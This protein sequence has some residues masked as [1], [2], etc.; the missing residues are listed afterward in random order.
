MGT[1]RLPSLHVE[2]VA[3][4]PCRCI[5]EPETPPITNPAEPSAPPPPAPGP[6]DDPARPWLLR[7]CCAREPAATAGATDETWA[8]PPAGESRQLRS[9][10]EEALLEPRLAG[11]TP[12]DTNRREVAGSSLAVTGKAGSSRRWGE[13]GVVSVTWYDANGE[14]TALP[15]PEGT[16]AVAVIAESLVCA[17]ANG[18]VD[19]CCCVAAKGEALVTGCCCIA[20]KGEKAD[21]EALDGAASVRVDACAAANGDGDGAPAAPANER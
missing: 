20:A 10:T 12:L 14:T 19:V 8:G 4:E 11:M 7:R 6:T 5:D 18:D 13:E 2:L 21:T 1:S 17:T 15:L 3:M 16:G 9:S